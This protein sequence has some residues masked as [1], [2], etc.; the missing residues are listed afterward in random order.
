MKAQVIIPIYQPDEK[1]IKLLRSIKLQEHVDFDVLIIDSGSDKKYL[2]E[3]DGI[4]ATVKEIDAASFNHGGTRQMGVEMFPDKD[5]FVFLTQD[6]ILADS[7]ALKN[8]LAAFR[9]SAVGCAY[10]RQL[11][12]EGAG[13]FAS[14]ARL[15]NYGDKS[16]VYKLADKEKHGMKTV[17]I[18]NSFAAYRRTALE[19]AGGFPT[20]TIL[21]EDMYAAA[22]MLPKGWKIAYC[23]DAMVYH[24][25]DYSI[26]Q[27]FKRYF[28]IG[29]FHATE[30]WIRETFG[31][32]EGAGRKF[33]ISEIKYLLRRNPVLLV[34]MVI[35]DGMK[36]LGY[37]LGLKHSCFSERVCA[38]L[39]MTKRYWF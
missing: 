23:A 10:G 15:C 21:C 30:S 32:A 12:H 20:H 2:T 1:L 36:F 7:F 3:L 22:K 25:H 33:V 18:S 8:L 16:Y 5:V 35:R 17:F 26:W 37:R 19:E 31:T 9:D 39:S 14:H 29:V 24:S 28:D 4:N 38:S 6:A 34:P 13:A 27:E 11:P